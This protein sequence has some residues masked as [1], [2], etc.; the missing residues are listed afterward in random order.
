MTPAPPPAT[1][2]LPAESA[3]AADPRAFSALLLSS[4]RLRLRPLQAADAPVVFA[5]HADPAA[6]RYWSTPPWTEARQADDLIARNQA[7]M[8]AGDYLCLGLELHGNGCLIGLCTLFAFHLP[9][10]RCETGYMLKRDCWGQGLMH[11]ALGTLLN[12]GFGV[13]DLNRVEADI[14]PRNAGSRRTLQ[15]LGFIEEGRLR[16]RWIVDG[17][18]SDSAL[19]GLLRRDW[20]AR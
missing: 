10:R 3:P 20:L 5:L 2:G 19:Y 1:S 9:S 4:Q 17:E 14:D 13:L 11:E 15:R 16:Q 7:A 8:A 6:M 18:V 12:F